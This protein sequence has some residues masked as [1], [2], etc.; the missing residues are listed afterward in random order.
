MSPEKLL[1]FLRSDKFPAFNIRVGGYREDLN[2]GFLSQ[3]KHP[4]FRSFSIQNEI[5]VA[6]GWPFDGDRFPNTLD[7]LRH[8]FNKV[9]VL[10]RWHRTPEA[11]D[12]DFYFVLGRVDRRF[13][14]EAVIRK[15]ENEMRDFMAGLNN[16][17]FTIDQTVLSIIGYLDTQL[18]VQTSCSFKIAD[19]ALDSRKLLDLYPASNL[20]D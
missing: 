19:P 15:V 1:D 16:R 11:I 9:N 13:L 14:S 17:V 10:H 4:Y 6:M 5:A 7:T 18:P 8:D 20:M 12:N 2:Y 3:N